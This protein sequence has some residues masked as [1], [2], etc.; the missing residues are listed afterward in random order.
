MRRVSGTQLRTLDEA[1]RLA[2]LGLLAEREEETIFLSSRICN[3]RLDAL[4]PNARLWG[5][6]RDGA[7]VAAMYQGN[8]IMPVGTD[9]EALT[10]FA[11]LMGERE[12]VKAILGPAPAV[13]AL[14]R[15]LSVRWGESWAITRS[16]RPH[17]PVLLLAQPPKV[18]PDARVTPVPLADLEPYYQAAVKMYLEEVGSS[19]YDATDSYRQYV[20]SLLRSRRA[21]GAKTGHDYW[22]KAD[23]GAAIPGVAQVQGVWL[24]RRYRGLGLSAALLSQALRYMQET[25]PHISLYVNDYNVRAIHLYATLGFKQVGEMATVLY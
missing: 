18:A 10:A 1:D 5:F 12:A 25:W 4:G 17:Q 21:F 14:H 9:P 20:H 3:G 23:V 22:F 7:L 16:L 11:D 6:F 2:L 13:L 19:P 24:D 15:H 8:N